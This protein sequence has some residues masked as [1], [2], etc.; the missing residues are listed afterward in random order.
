MFITDFISLNV[1]EQLEDFLS[2]LV[3]VYSFF[4]QGH[5]IHQKFHICWHKDVHLY[6]Y[7][8]V[9]SLFKI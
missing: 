9:H 1:L 4:P 3:F 6:S 7:Y 8:E 5:L 2:L